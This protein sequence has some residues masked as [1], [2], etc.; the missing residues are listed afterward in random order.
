[1]P[2]NIM[3][4]PPPKGSVSTTQFSLNRSPRARY[5]RAL[6]SFSRS[7]ILVSS[8]N[9][10]FA[11]SAIVNLKWRQS[12]YPVSLMKHS[13]SYWSTA[14]QA[15]RAK[16]INNSL[17]TDLAIVS[18]NDT[19]C[20]T[21]GCGKSCASRWPNDVSVL[22]PGS[23]SPSGPTLLISNGPCLPEFCP[24]LLDTR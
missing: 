23:Y 8:T 11:Q 12:C 22:S 7:E 14:G 4:E 13:P 24:Q 15:N 21:S 16:T 2:A 9:R 17:G 18:T 3:I 1:M 6:P 19:P 5:T 10:T 20:S